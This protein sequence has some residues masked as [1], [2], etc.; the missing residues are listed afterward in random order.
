MEVMGR[1][2][3]SHP[4]VEAQDAYDDYPPAGGLVDAPVMASKGV[5]LQASAQNPRHEQGAWRSDSQ[6]T[7]YPP[8]VIPTINIQGTTPRSSY[9]PSMSPPHQSYNTTETWQ[10]AQV[11]PASATSLDFDLNGMSPLDHTRMEARRQGSATSDASWQ[12][13]SETG[14]G[15]VDRDIGFA[16]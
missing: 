12:T 2:R 8:Q 13:A 4:D 14:G 6:S 11:P 10:Y 7:G 3:D 1:F 9:A 5:D 15:T 16:R